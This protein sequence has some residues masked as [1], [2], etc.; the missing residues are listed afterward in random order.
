M[1]GASFQH[2]LGKKV[3]LEGPENL[4]QILVLVFRWR[5]KNTNRLAE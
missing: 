3:E 1:L 4:N 5:N 2:R